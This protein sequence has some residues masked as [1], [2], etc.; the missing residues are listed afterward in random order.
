MFGKYRRNSAAARILEEQLYEQVVNELSSGHKRNGLWAKAFVD[1]GGED[2]KAKALYIKYRVQSIKDECELYKV[3][4]E[5][6][7]I[8]SMQKVEE[9]NRREEQDRQNKKF[10]EESIEKKKQKWKVDIKRASKYLD[11]PIPSDEFC[12][13]Y[14]LTKEKLNSFIGRGLIEGYEYDGELYVQDDNPN[15]LL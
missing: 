4:K 2:E 8:H 9:E 13:K 10:Y 5:Q 6:E 14:N 11:R 1:S 3:T 7:E 12:E 15:K